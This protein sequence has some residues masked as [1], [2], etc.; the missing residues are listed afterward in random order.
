MPPGLGANWAE[1]PRDCDRLP[2]TPC[3]KHGEDLDLR[4]VRLTK[5]ASAAGPQGRAHTN[6]RCL[7]GASGACWPS[8]V[9]RPL[10]ACRLHARVRPH[11]WPSPASR[12]AY[13][14]STTSAVPV[15]KRAAGDARTVRPQRI[16]PASSVASES[17]GAETPGDMHDLLSELAPPACQEG[18]APARR[19]TSMASAQSTEK[20]RRSPATG[21]TRLRNSS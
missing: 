2:R 6:R 18:V 4:E 17:A 5:C 12:M 8:G 7:S 9:R 15:T 19:P 16:Q 10:P 20:A 14:P 11:D 3:R 13:P 21:S 1:M